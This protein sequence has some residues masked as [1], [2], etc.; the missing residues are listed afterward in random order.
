MQKIEDKK[1]TDNIHKGVILALILIVIFS[2]IGS[3]VLFGEQKQF[4]YEQGFKAGYDCGLG[5][6]N[7]LTKEYIPMST[8]DCEVQ[9]DRK[10]ER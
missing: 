2:F 6:Y 10:N 9:Y 7:P 3:I 8:D 4:I 5:W 1:E